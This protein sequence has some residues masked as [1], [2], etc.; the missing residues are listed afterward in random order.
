MPFIL[1]FNHLTFIKIIYM[2]RCFITLTVILL[3]A[4]AAKAQQAANADLYLQT[5]EMNDMMVNYAADKGS[6]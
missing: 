2:R 3:F 4:T 1:S 6:I 5:S